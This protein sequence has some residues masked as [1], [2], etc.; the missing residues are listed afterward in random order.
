MQMLFKMIPRK[1]LV[2]F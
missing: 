2:I 1:M